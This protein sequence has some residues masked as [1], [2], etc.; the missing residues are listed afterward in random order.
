MAGVGGFLFAGWKGTVGRDDFSLLT[1]SLSSLPLLLLAVVGGIT[2][3]SGAIIGALLLVAMPQVAVA[4]PSLNNLMILL[5]GL[6]GISL[7]RNPDGIASDVRNAVLISRREIAAWL[8]ARGS[9]A[10]IRR[11]PIVPELVGRHRPVT[12]AE[13]RAL[14]QGLGFTVEDCNG[15]A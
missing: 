5:P 2:V 12:A 15:A 11:E 7:A 8:R 4:Y 10:S 14:E 3:A 1:G 6:A 13:L 9:P